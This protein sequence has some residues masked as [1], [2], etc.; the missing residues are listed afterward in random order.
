MLYVNLFT[1][2]LKVYSYMQAQ[3]FLYR[4]Q[5]TMKIQRTSARGD[6]HYTTR[7]YILQRSMVL[8][9]FSFADLVIS[10]K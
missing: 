4:E 6:V 8:I 5:Y 7:L 1:T 2:C 9:A 10:L 3:V